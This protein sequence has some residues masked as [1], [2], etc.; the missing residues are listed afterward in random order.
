MGAR[1]RQS[2]RPVFSLRRQF[3]SAEADKNQKSKGKRKFP[4]AKLQLIDSGW[5]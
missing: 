2:R 1:Q 3:R 5:I 4:K